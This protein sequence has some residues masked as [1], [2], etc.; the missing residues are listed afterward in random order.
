MKPFAVLF[1]LLGLC[2]LAAAP[3]LIQSTGVYSLSESEKI[4]L[5][6]KE[7]IVKLTRLSNKDGLSIKVALG[8]KMYSDTDNL[9]WIFDGQSELIRVEFTAA[10]IVFQESL[11][12]SQLW[13]EAPKRFE[14]M[15]PKNR[16]RP[17]PKPGGDPSKNPGTFRPAF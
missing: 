10:K 16:L 6:E 12:T 9:L 13:S 7:G 5:E 2:P 14:A 4:S 8:W 11:Y 1:L 17:L 15:L 3:Q